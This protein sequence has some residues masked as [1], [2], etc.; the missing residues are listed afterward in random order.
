MLG[1]PPSGWCAWRV[2]VRL[3]P[4]SF[5]HVCVRFIFVEK[6]RTNKMKKNVIRSSALVLVFCLPALLAGC[7]AHRHLH[8]DTDIEQR[9][10]VDE[11]VDVSRDSASSVHSKTVT[12]D[13]RST[14][15]ITWTYDTSMPSDP[16][17]HRP[18]LQ[19]FT[20]EGEVQTETQDTTVQEESSFSENIQEETHADRDIDVGIVEDSDTK[21][22]FKFGRLLGLLIPGV[23][24][25]AL[26][27]WFYKY[28]RPNTSK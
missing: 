8:T 12:T 19:S 2:C 17:T 20:V 11:N 4:L 25:L 18:P 26:L 23:L 14:W 10:S 21:A 24:I 7:G 28:A 22:E 13:D 16:E 27:L 15:R 5:T 1:A 9:E 6:F 3:L